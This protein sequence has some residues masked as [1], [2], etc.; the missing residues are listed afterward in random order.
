MYVDIYILHFNCTA[1]TRPDPVGI[2][3]C[4]AGPAVTLNQSPSNVWDCPRAV[5]LT[6]NPPVP[7]IVASAPTDDAPCIGM[8]DVYLQYTLYYPNPHYPN[9]W[10]KDNRYEMNV[11]NRLIVSNRFIVTLNLVKK[12]GVY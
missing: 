4:A 11:S 5:I 3:G 2:Y 7:V 12:T 6:I 9:L 10:A 1:K 8:R